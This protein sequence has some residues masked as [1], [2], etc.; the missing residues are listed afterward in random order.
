MKLYSYYEYLLEVKNNEDFYFINKVIYE[1][2]T[3]YYII[4]KDFKS[5]VTVYT[6]NDDPK[7]GYLGSLFVSPDYRNDGRGKEIF[8]LGENLLRQLNYKY[9]C[10]AVKKESWVLDWYKRLGYVYNYDKKNSNLV[11]LLKKL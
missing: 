7:T 4:S 6:Y 8:E 10:L 2:I 5:T 11:W 9:S 3:Y 1:R